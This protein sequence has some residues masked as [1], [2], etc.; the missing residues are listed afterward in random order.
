MNEYL[1]ANKC[2]QGDHK[3]YE[4]DE[5]NELLGVDVEKIT[6]DFRNCE[7]EDYF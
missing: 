4:K 7:N 2:L 5:D 6:E 3:L 1:C